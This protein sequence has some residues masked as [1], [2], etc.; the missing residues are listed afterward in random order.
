M[1]VRLTNR[2]VPFF[3]ALALSLLP[4]VAMAATLGFAPSTLTRSFGQ[5]FTTTVFVGSAEESMNAAS[6]VI[7][8]STDKLEVVSLSKTGSIMSL[9][10]QEPSY[11]NQNGTINFEGVVLNPG[12]QGA[13][14]NLLTITFK[15]KAVGQASAKF[16]SGTVLANDGSGSNILSGM[17]SGSFVISSG[18]AA[19]TTV[20]APPPTTGD[21]S[22]IT[23][24]THPDQSKW[25]ANS[26][27]EFSWVL[28][29]GALEVRTAIGSSPEVMPT[30]SYAPPISSK[31]VDPQTDGVYYFAL[32][33][34]TAEGWGDVARYRVNID[35]TPPSPFSI[36]FPHGNKSLEP[37]PVILFNTTDNESGIGGYEVVIDGKGPSKVAPSA[38]SNPYPLPPQVPGSYTVT[39]TAADEAGNSRSASESFVIE[40]IDAPLITYYKEEIVYG[41]IVKIGGTTYPNSE[42]HVV[43]RERDEIVAEEHTKSNSLGDFAIVATKRLPSGDYTFTARVTDD[44]GAM[45]NETSPLPLT[46]KSRFLTDLIDLTL[47]YLSAAF[48]AILALA[49]LFGGGAYIWYRS[50]MLVRRLR[51][52][53]SEA[54]TVLAKSFELLRRD[55]FEHASQ[56]RAL[57]RKLTKEETFFLE[58][59]ASNLDDAE[60]IIIKEIHDIGRPR[61]A[62]K[63]SKKGKGKIV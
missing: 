12:Y 42:V 35:T 49:L 54:E 47:D 31:K 8:F 4:T 18:S 63:K 17:G 56:L 40:A 24:T 38:D 29:L 13:Q 21:G 9:W 60:K 7:S 27:P 16:T 61:K 58:R 37:Q 50:F 32:R 10:V 36:T 33:I 19:E 46:V 51:R 57:K 44:R 34:R 3:F 45:S 28:P 14:G 15:A 41:D 43:I 26:A 59:F 20:A 62:K 53:S 2:I 1:D 48:L 52:E 30:V 11:S 22:T 39:V 5:T 25:Y 23:S 6:G 55:V